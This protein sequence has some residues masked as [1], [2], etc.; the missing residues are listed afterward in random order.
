M[1]ASFGAKGRVTLK[2]LLRADV[3]IKDARVM[4]IGP[5]GEHLVNAAMLCNDFNH[6]ASHSGGAIFG[7]KML[8]GIVVYG[9]K[10]PPLHDKAALIEA[11]LRWRKTLQQYS[12][13]DRYSTGHARHLEAL[14]NNNMQSTLIGDHNRGFDQN[15]VVQRPCFQCARLCPWDV[16]IGEGE[17]KGKVGHFNAGAEWLDTFWNLGVKG[18]ATLYLAER[19]NDLGIECG[20]FSFGAGV[21]FE[22]YEKGLVTEKDC[23][24]MRLE[25][26]NVEAIDKLL[27]MTARR[28][29]KWGNLIA[30]GPL[31]V[32][33]AIGGDAVQLGS[34]HQARRAGDARLAAA[35]LEH[36]ARDRRQ[37]RH[38]TAGRRS[39]QS[40]AGFEVPRKVGAA[41]PRRS[42]GLAAVQRQR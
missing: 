42:D 21:L 22:A 1:R 4:G 10:R 41:R 7:S 31:E 6:S 2:K 25:W 18:N 5:A 11:G 13:K 12:L 30:D 20:H 35:F 9:T 32:A 39:G 28:Q 36:A 19:I 26:G 37:R 24:G 29:G 16:E 17:F 8:K 34:P 23:D 14:P 15:R 3:G 40:A 38:E 33:E 27:T